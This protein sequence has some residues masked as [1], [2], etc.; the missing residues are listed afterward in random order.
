MKKILSLL[1][2]LVFL[3]Y[4]GYS[5][6]NSWRCVEVIN[7]AIEGNPTAR[8]A[9]FDNVEMQQPAFEPTPHAYKVVFH[10]I[11]DDNSQ[12]PEFIGENIVMNVI[13]DLNVTYKSAKIY[14]KYGG[15]DYV[16]NTELC[17]DFLISQLSTAFPDYFNDHSVIHMII[18]NGNIVEY[19]DSDGIA[20]TIPG[21]GFMYGGISFYNYEGIRSRRVPPHEVGH[22]FGLR[23]VISDTENVVRSSTIAGFN[24]DNAGDRLVDT[25]ACKAWSVEQFD[26]SGTYVG[27]DIDNNTLLP[28]TDENRLYR[29]QNPKVYNAMYVYDGEGLAFNSQITP[30]QNMRMDYVINTD[31]SNGSNALYGAE[32]PLEEL[33]KPF[34]SLLVPSP[35]VVSVTDNNDGT[36]SVCHS[37]LRKD[38]FQKGFESEF[39][40]DELELFTSSTSDGLTEIVSAI[41]NY[42]VKLP[43]ISPDNTFII[44]VPCYRGTICQNEDYVSGIVYS[45]QVLGSMNV[46][47][48]ELDQIE[49]KDPEL[50]NK[51]M[52]E[53]YHILKKYTTSGAVDEKV[54]YKP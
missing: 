49:V 45:M 20:H 33:Y 4:H 10:I 54:I 29:S 12:R 8:Y 18:L 28:D 46:S 35:V 39:L 11:R 50:Y 44:S 27:P 43:E 48:K 40:T 30:E 51:L 38:R 14:F 17:G 32:V 37:I 9:A 41:R 24:A 36:A 26:S 15:F 1:L 52:V 13:K 25:P 47:V 16:D 2:F 6:I 22:N 42:R 3:N 31:I 5:Q 7:P 19:Y 21:I 53:Y 23:H 34:E